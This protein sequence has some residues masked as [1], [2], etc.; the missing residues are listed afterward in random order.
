MAKRVKWTRIMDRYLRQKYE[1][2]SA[3]QIAAKLNISKH[4]VH[5][6]VNKLKLGS[7]R[8][9]ETAICRVYSSDEADFIKANAGKLS[10][11]QIARELGRTEDSVHSKAKR[12]GLT[13]GVKHRRLTAEQKSIIENNIQMMTYRDIAK[14][15]NR[16]EE[17]TRWHARQLGLSRRSKPTTRTHRTS[18]SQEFLE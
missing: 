2:L 6:R 12:L 13:I 16:S 11:S 15:I 17:Q 8:H 18:S 9:L 14:L 5:R 4:A 3:R 10:V 1:L 7:K